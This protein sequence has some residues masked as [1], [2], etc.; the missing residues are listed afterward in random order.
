M[1]SRKSALLSS[2]SALRSAIPA[3]AA[4]FALQAAAGGIGFWGGSMDTETFGKGFAAGAQV[5]VG[6][7][8]WVSLLLRG[9]Y[10]GGFDDVTLR[11]AGFTAGANARK[12]LQRVGAD[13][14]A[15]E[16]EDFGLVPLEVGLVLRPTA[17]F[18]VIGV[19]AGA[20]AG[21]YYLPGFDIVDR[22]AKIS[23][24]EASD[25][26]GWW[27]LAGADIGISFFHVFAEAKYTSAKNDDET[28]D[29]D[30]HGAAGAVRGDIDLTGLTVL[31]GI[32]FEW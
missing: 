30:W 23:T 19:Y 6:T 29:I 1:T 13:S 20:G 8:P 27:A 21:Y 2:V 22:G 7:V 12:I 18:G 15:A 14:A 10:A 16:M 31:G 9:G 32:R 28:F 4:A 17:L 26:F 25:L 5:E 3:L 11:D 24:D